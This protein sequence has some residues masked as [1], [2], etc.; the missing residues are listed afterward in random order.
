MNILA[1]NISSSFYMFILEVLQNAL[2]LRSQRKHSIEA[3]DVDNTT[4]TPEARSFIDT[5]LNAVDTRMKRINPISFQVNHG[6]VEVEVLSSMLLALMS[7][8]F[9]FK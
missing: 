7:T 1:F 2:T 9:S 3:P 4:E 6:M 8:V 5:T